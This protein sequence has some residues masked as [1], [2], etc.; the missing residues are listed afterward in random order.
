ML[1]LCLNLTWL[2][3]VATFLSAAQCVRLLA[4]TV[5]IDTKAR[6]LFTFG[7]SAASSAMLFWANTFGTFASPLVV[8]GV[9]IGGSLVVAGWV[10]VGQ[11]VARGLGYEP[12][13]PAELP[14][15][16]PTT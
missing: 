11:A 14:T 1:A 7:W 16:E 12:P 10:L 6:L 9:T 3:T 2:P 13:P 8:H 15:D 5:R 4:Y